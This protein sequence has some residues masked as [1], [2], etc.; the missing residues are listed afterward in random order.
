MGDQVGRVSINVRIKVVWTDGD[1]VGWTYEWVFGRS[2]VPDQTVGVFAGGQLVIPPAEF[3]L[4]GDRITRVST[5]KVI[6]QSA[7]RFTHP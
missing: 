3:E 1:K 6:P 7:G 5:I 2:A 4:E